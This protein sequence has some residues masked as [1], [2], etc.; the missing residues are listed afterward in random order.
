[1]IEYAVADTCTSHGPA[2]F[3]I[4][5]MTKIEGKWILDADNS[6]GIHP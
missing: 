2:A 1:M 5:V 3:A 4:K 6:D